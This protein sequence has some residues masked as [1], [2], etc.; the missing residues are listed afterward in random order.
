MAAAGKSQDEARIRQVLDEWLH[1]IHR[2]D[3][4]AVLSHYAP[5]LVTYDLIPPLQHKGA[6]A[7]RKVLEAWLAAIDGPV[8]YELHDVDIQVSDSLAL[9]RSV[10]HMV[11]RHREG[12]DIDN[13]ICGTLWLKKGSGA[14]KIAHQHFSAP[15]D[16]KTGKA[17]L[18]LGR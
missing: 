10:N 16:M 8:S 9:V 3:A 6:A 12:R 4:D 1:A 2:K 5:D 13:W 11:F 7:Y 17:L 14:W 15:F 18:D